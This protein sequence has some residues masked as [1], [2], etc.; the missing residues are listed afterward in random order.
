MQDILDNA[1]RGRGTSNYDLEFTTKSN[2][3]RYLLVNATTRRDAQNNI[4]GVVGVAQDV[5]ETAQHDRGMCILIVFVI[6]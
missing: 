6:I 3:T 4:V 5:T 2:E 1:L